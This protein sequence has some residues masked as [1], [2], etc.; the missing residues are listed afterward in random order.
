[1]RS[2]DRRRLP[3]R[4]APAALAARRAGTRSLLVL[5]GGAVLFLFLVGILATRGSADPRAAPSDG[6]GSAERHAQALGLEQ[7]TCVTLEDRT[8]E[9]RDLLSSGR[10]V[11]AVDL[12]TGTLAGSTAS[13]CPAAHG[14]LAQLWY[15]A[16][17]DSILATTPGDSTLAAR[18]PARWTEVEARADSLGVPASG[19]RPAM[20]VARA[21]YDRGLW[22]LADAGFRRG[23]DDGA[24]GVESVEFRHA[25]L[26]NW[27][28]Q[29]AAENTLAGRE[30]GLGMLATAH[31]IAR[32]YDLRT[33]VAC[34]DMRAL[35]IADCAKTVPDPSEPT[36]A[37]RQ[38]GSAG[39]LNAAIARPRGP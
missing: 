5:A 35:G 30:Q 10:L 9:V 6:V 12:A 25:L 31:A 15:E 32:T 27:G 20:Q 21:A 1:M 13:A 11:P 38:P 14:I 7:A 2:I 17:L 23:A 3:A 37:G 8:D 29:L 18:T 34:T 28:R 22:Q 4:L 19:R 26:R 33:D 24:P 36:L 16:A 39:Q